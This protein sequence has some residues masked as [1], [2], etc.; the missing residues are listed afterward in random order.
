MFRFRPTHTLTH[1]VK[2][3]ESTVWTRQEVPVQTVL[4][5]RRFYRF[6]D[7]TAPIVSAACTCSEFIVCV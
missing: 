4:S 3:A 6:C 1:N 7:M 2:V 5:L